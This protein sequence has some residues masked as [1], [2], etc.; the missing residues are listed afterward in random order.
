MKERNLIKILEVSLQKVMLMI[1]HLI[2]LQKALRE[3]LINSLKSAI[4]LKI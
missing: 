4:K 1:K 2:S 3:I